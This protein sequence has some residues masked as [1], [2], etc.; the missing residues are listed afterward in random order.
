MGN[1]GLDRAG[2]KQISKSVDSVLIT[3]TMAACSAT[4]QWV[5]IEVISSEALIKSITAAGLTN[6]SL[7][8]SG[9]TFAQNAVIECSKI[10]VVQLATQIAAGKVIAHERVLI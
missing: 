10:T 4:Q 2:Y 1:P 9:T 7:I 3:T 5:S 8:D 6:A